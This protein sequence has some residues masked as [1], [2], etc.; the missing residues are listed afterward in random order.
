MLKYIT[1]YKTF[2]C[3]RLFSVVLNWNMTSRDILK[4][5]RISFYPGG[6][7]LELSSGSPVF[8]FFFFLSFF[9]YW[10]SWL[11]SIF[12][13]LNYPQRLKG[14]SQIHLIVAL[15][16]FRLWALEQFSLRLK[17]LSHAVSLSCRAWDEFWWSLSKVRQFVQNQNAMTLLPRPSLVPQDS[18]RKE[19]Y[20]YIIHSWMVWIYHSF[21]PFLPFQMVIWEWS[22]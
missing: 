18:S 14:S 21:F 13:L 1:I 10:Y 16:Q 4:Q 12:W 20:E 3:L 6:W 19:W 5:R 15:K 11:H 9:W 8:F 22:W 2:V 17:R 7:R